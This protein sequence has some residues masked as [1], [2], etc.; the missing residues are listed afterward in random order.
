MSNDASF[1]FFFLKGPAVAVSPLATPDAEAHIVT[2]RSITS[3]WNSFIAPA[4]EAAMEMLAVPAE[5]LAD[6]KVR[7]LFRFPPSA[8]PPSRLATFALPSWIE[9]E[10]AD[11]PRDSCFMLTLQDGRKTYGFSLQMC[12]KCGP[13]DSSLSD[14]RLEGNSSRLQ[15][16]ALVR[17]CAVPVFV[18]VY[19]SPV[20]VR[21]ALL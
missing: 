10:R 1:H 3:A 14:G 19:V 17:S 5:S 4:A 15:L 11:S 21:P 13:D 16:S 9:R 20:H 6:S 2:L 18:C 12:E 8:V 7:V